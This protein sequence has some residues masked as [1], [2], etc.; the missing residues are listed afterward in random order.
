M[1]HL[2]AQEGFD[3]AKTPLGL[4]FVLAVTLFMLVFIFVGAMYMRSQEQLARQARAEQKRLED[5]E[6]GKAASSRFQA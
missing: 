4:L 6:N 2:L 5:E 3:R 1:L